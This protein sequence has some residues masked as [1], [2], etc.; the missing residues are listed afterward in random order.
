MFNSYPTSIAVPKHTLTYMVVPKDT[1]LI[2]FWR[3][4]TPVAT[5]A[6][7]SSTF[8]RLAAT[9]ANFADEDVMSTNFFL[10]KLNTVFIKINL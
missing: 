10:K 5:S 4:H 9:S 3:N 6:V 8:V 2:I 7:I 1:R